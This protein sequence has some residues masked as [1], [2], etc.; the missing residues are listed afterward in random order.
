M[1][2]TGLRRMRLRSRRPVRG[3]SA[4]VCQWSSM[5]DKEVS[6][7]P[8][9]ALGLKQRQL[10]HASIDLSKPNPLGGVII[11]VQPRIR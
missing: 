10:F 6:V 8:S 5:T 1:A 2:A 9:S 11:V 4:K 3:A 7:S